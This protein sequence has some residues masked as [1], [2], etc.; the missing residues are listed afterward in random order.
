MAT[1]D[2]KLNLFKVRM[3]E[4]TISS[5]TE[6]LMS[7]F[8]TQGQKVEEFESA[9]QKYFNHKYVLTL[10]SATSGLTLAC[11]LLNGDRAEVNR[12]GSCEILSTPLTCFA[13]TAAILAN[14]L[15]IRWVDVDPDTCNM[16]LDDLKRKITHN[17]KIIMVVHWGGT[18]VDLDKLKDIQDEA[19]SRYGF[20]PYVI[21]DCAHAFGATYNDKKLGTHGN[22]CIYSLQ[23]IK[24]LTTGDGG[25]LL[26]PDEL[27]YQRGKLLRWYGIDRE[28]RNVGGKDFRLENDIE[29][30]GYKFHMNDINA[31][32][33]LYNLINVKQNLKK[34]Q[35][36]AQHYS[37]SLNNIDGITLLKDDPKSQSAYWLF[38]LKVDRKIEF[39]KYMEDRDI[40]VSQVHQRNDIHSCVKE[41]KIDLPNLDKLETEMICIPVGWWLNETDCDYI[42]RCIKEFSYSSS[43]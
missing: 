12:V 24:H 23:A 14:G 1:R 37:Q 28:K 20:R 29:E 25:L 31:T 34:C 30:W 35:S 43:Q 9:L 17:T 27:L 8:I 11:R 3:D 15:K 16:D 4:D 32:I 39:M 26:V 22:L 13:T 21:E 40:M 7:G 38:T 5:L 10:N 33:G 6:T 2:L 41:F 42:I 18:P 19:E 36:N